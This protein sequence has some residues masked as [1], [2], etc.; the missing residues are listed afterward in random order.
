[1]QHELSIAMNNAPDVPND[2]WFAM[3]RLDENRA[4]HNWQRNQ[5]DKS[6]RFQMSP[7]G[8]IIRLLNTRLL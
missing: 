5:T 8:G 7:F 1:M 2:R 4:L 6:Q 3:T